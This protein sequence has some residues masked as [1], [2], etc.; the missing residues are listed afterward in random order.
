MANADSD[1][2]IGVYAGSSPLRLA[3]HPGAQNPV[4]RGADVSDVDADFV[5]D[6]FVL[7]ENG[8]WYLFFEVLNATVNRGEIGLATS[9]DGLAWRYEG[10]VL[11][12]PQHL[13]YPYVFRSQ[14]AIYMVPETNEA[15]AVQL[16]RAEPF[17]GRWRPV[18]TLFEAEA[19]DSSIVHHADT[20][21]LFTCTTPRAQ[22][23][24]RLFYADSLESSW[25][26]HPRSPIVDGDKSAARPAGRVVVD[27]DRIV[28][29]AQD[30]R[31]GYGMGIVAFEI[32]G[33][34]RSAY[35]ERRHLDGPLASPNAEAWCS[36]R[37]HHVDP[38]RLPDGTWIA[39]VDGD[40]R[41]GRRKCSPGLNPPAT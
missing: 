2:A 1:W 10:I 18:A 28:R 27:G 17:P 36:A 9:R 31:D 13:S 34:T 7:R 12:E 33:L 38:C 6:P 16:Y 20:W 26:E 39:Y 21:W 24:L 8:A 5:A 35:A 19:V 4:L 29:Y 40:S 14:G 11:R 22:D 37:M 15:G 23:C 25:T 3:P 41:L 30:C 32:E